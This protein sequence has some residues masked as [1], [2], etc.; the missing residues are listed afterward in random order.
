MPV[1]APTTLC[2]V[3]LQNLQVLLNLFCSWVGFPIMQWSWTAIEDG[4]YLGV[5]LDI[6]KPIF[7]DTVILK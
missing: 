6:G 2:C 1:L 7:C 4:I 3:D 5:T